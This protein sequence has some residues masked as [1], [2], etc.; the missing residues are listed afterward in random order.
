M[1]RIKKREDPHDSRNGPF[2]E[3]QGGLIVMWVMGSRRDRNRTRE[4]KVQGRICCECAE[5][6]ALGSAMETLTD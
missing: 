2:L 4:I 3:Y 1:T 6:P 5:Q